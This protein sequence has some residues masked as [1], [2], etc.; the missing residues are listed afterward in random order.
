MRLLIGRTPAKCLS[1]QPVCGAEGSEEVLD[2]HQ[3]AIPVMS[4][5]VRRADQ[6]YAL[7]LWLGFGGAVGYFEM[8]TGSC[9]AIV[10]THDMG[11]CG[12]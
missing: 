9:E 7:K 3:V 2:S 8:G 1:T 5:G 6:V 11:H 12:P 4:R 10:H